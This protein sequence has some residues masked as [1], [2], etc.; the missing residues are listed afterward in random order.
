MAMANVMMG[1]LDAMTAAFMDLVS[2]R[3]MKKKCNIYRDS[4]ESIKKEDQYRLQILVET[5]YFL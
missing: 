2:V 4:R 3:P 1:A 5:R